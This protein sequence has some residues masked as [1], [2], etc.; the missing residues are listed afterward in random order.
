LKDLIIGFNLPNIFLA[1]G[2]FY[3]KEMLMNTAFY[4]YAWGWMKKTS[5][6]WHIS[7]EFKIGI[8]GNGPYERAGGDGG[9]FRESDYFD[10]YQ[11]KVNTGWHLKLLHCTKIQNLKGK[12]EKAARAL[13]KSIKND[14]SNN[15][16]WSHRDEFFNASQG[17]NKLTT[18]EWLERTV[19]VWVATKA[20]A[21]LDLLS[22]DLYSKFIIE[23]PNNLYCKLEENKVKKAMRNLAEYRS[24]YG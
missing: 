23:K 10:F 21:E 6:K 15:K 3:F 5:W 8:S 4:F 17:E 19:N 13:E 11:N 18:G 16:V 20:A 9:F 1:Q 12:E 22:Y 24:E 7:R 2:V 14:L